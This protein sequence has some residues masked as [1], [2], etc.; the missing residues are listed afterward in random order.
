MQ[1]SAYVPLCEQGT[2]SK[3]GSFANLTAAPPQAAP[4]S[5]DAQTSTL[6]HPLPKTAPISYP[7]VQGSRIPPFKG[8]PP[9][10]APGA[11]SSHLSA[12]VY[13]EPSF[14]S[15]AMTQSLMHGVHLASM[16]SIIDLYISSCQRRT[17]RSVSFK[18]FS[19][20]MFEGRYNRMETR[21]A[22]SAPPV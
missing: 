19:L 3:R 4:R 2:L 10:G 21:Q 15:S 8:P 12:S 11:T 5:D 13:L 1:S 20:R 6:L 17:T 14:S 18:T 9:E 22:L 16:Q 7:P